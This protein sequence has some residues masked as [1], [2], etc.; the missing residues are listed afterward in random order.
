MPSYSKYR[1]SNAGMTNY[2]TFV[3]PSQF[4]QSH[5]QQSSQVPPDSKVAWDDW[6]EAT[7]GYMGAPP[8][9]DA[10][11]FQSGYGTDFMKRP[12]NLFAGKTPTLKDALQGFGKGIAEFL[13]DG[14]L[15]TLDTNTGIKTQGYGS[16]LIAAGG[17]LSSAIFANKGLKLA[18]DTQRNNQ[19]QFTLNFNNAA[20][21]IDDRRLANYGRDVAE[22][23]LNNKAAP[24]A[25]KPLARA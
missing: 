22:A 5:Y 12:D 18:K 7:R 25:F 19:R 3:D 9:N 14:F 1:P 23:K 13:P 17:A 16:P 15:D 10:S 24:S 20:D 4:Q 8:P 11:L 6:G 2:G 21:V